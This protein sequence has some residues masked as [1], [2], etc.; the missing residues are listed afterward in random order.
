MPLLQRLLDLLERAK[1][2]HYNERSGLTS[3]PMAS[4]EFNA[5][6]GYPLSDLCECGAKEINAEIDAMI[7]E[8]KILYGDPKAPCPSGIIDVANL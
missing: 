5:A 4:N 1:H 6:N 2:E 7:E 3:C 8:L